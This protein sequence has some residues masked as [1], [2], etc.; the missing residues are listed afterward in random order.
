[1]AKDKKTKLNWPLVLILLILIFTTFYLAFVL[2]PKTYGEPKGPGEFG[3]MFGGINAL[4]SG[5]ALVGIVFA[6]LLQSRELELQRME[7]EE[8]RKELKG[9][10]EQL[11]EQNKTL[12]MASIHQVLVDLMLEYRSS[13]MYSAV[14]ALWAFYNKYGNDFVKEYEKTMKKESGDMDNSLRLR[15]LTLKKQPSTFKED[16]FHIFMNYLGGF[17]SWALCRGTSYTPT[18]KN[19]IY[20]F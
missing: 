8:T 13:E 4:F 12:R 3:D 6:I 20:K 17:M 5:L 16:S 7:L 1:M 14:K 11:K 19:Q 9:Q 18:G 15:E 2:I 10:K